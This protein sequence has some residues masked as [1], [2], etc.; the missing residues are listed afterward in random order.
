M[1]CD[2]L[3]TSG[4]WINSWRI[5]HVGWSSTF[6]ATAGKSC[7][8][9]SAISM[10]HRW[11]ATSWSEWS[12][13]SVIFS[14]EHKDKPLKSIPYN[15]QIVSSF[16]T[17]SN[18]TGLSLVSFQFSGTENYSIWI[19]AMM[20]NLLARNKLGFNVKCEKDN[21]DQFLHH[22]SDR[23]NVYIFAWIMNVVSRQLL[24]III[25]STSAFHV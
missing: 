13:N 12:N 4:N 6:G 17:P 21:L 22:L 8:L 14:T 3:K 24:S 15:S 2:I 5:I 25:Y 9:G 10:L 7:R 19:R 23:C 11:T 20:T 16:F 18:T 1:D